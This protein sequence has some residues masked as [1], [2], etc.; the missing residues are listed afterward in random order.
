MNDENIIDMEQVG[1]GETYESRVDYDKKEDE[2]REIIRGR[3]TT[4]VTDLS[5]SC[6]EMQT[7]INN[8]EKEEVARAI[9]INFSENELLSFKENI[10]ALNLNL[11]KA[12]PMLDSYIT[13][14]NT[15]PK[16]DYVNNLIYKLNKFMIDTQKRRFYELRL[17]HDDKRYFK[18]M[19]LSSIVEELSM[20]I[21]RIKGTME[22]GGQ[23][24]VDFPKVQS[25][26]QHGPGT[27]NDGEFNQGP[28]NS[29]YYSGGYS[30]YRG[31]KEYSKM[32][33]AQRENELRTK[34]VQKTPLRDIGDG[35]EDK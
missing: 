6:E 21:E 24:I 32:L 9:R 10:K 30:P 11:G 27:Y 5:N 8:K 18:Y 19:M 29:P 20:L 33:E 17:V 1:E 25:T 23:F 3:F 28:Y 15:T 14:R 26:N 34:T 35:Y 31:G 16:F 13:F 12:R 7:A 2:K 22:T 4:I